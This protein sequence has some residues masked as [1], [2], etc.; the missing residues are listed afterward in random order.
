MLCSEMDRLRSCQGSVL[1]R[2]CG[3]PAAT[4]LNDL[5]DIVLRDPHYLRFGYRPDCR[6]HGAESVSS[7]SLRPGGE[8]AIVAQTSVDG[9]IA[10]RASSVR[11]TTSL[12]APPV[13]VDRR[14][15]QVSRSA[16][17]RHQMAFLKLAVVALF[18]T[19]AAVHL[20]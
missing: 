13:S 12:A 18:L 8:S 2:N 3:T 6:L 1:K 16:A 4:V 19:V 5:F 20:R 9:H 7:P 17:S 15:P 11:D 14:Q 10:A